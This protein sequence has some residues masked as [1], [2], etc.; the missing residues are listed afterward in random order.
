VTTGD[1]TAIGN[2]SHTQI[3]QVVLAILNVT[4]SDP[5][6]LTN[7]LVVIQQTASVVNSGQASAN[8]GGNT[9]SATILS[10]LAG[11]GSQTA[12]QLTSLIS[13][14]AS[15]LTGSATAIGN[16]SWTEIMQVAHTVVQINGDT[17]L[18]DRLTQIQQTAGVTNSGSAVASTGGN[19]VNVQLGPWGPPGSGGGPAEPPNEEDA[20]RFDFS[21]RLP[22]IEVVGAPNEPVLIWGLADSAAAE[23]RVAVDGR[24]CKVARVSAEPEVDAY[25]WRVGLKQGECGT[26]DGSR[27]AMTI[28]GEPTKFNVVWRETNRT[29]SKN[30]VVSVHGTRTA[31]VLSE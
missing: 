13:G 29:L 11:A 18:L 6:Q 10:G 28:D 14:D 30:S 21:E 17:S 3:V 19:N 22:R 25:M 9:S 20:A 7:P 1:A 8:T 24:F 27:V 16:M 31:S 4:I 15:V 5:T 2:L 12:A 23:V 26:E